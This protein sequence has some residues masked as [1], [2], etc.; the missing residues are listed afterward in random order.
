MERKERRWRNPEDCRDAR[1]V[2]KEKQGE[3]GVGRR[4]G[5]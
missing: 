2:E 5:R 3:R 4:D 1:G